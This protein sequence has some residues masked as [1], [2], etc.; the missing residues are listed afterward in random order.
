MLG[1][2]QIIREEVMK[3]GPIS[4]ARFMELA[5]YCPES[6]F[7]EKEPDNVGRGG[8]FYTSVSVGPLFGELLAFQFSRWLEEH[9][10][11]GGRLV[12]AGAHDG[13]LAADILGW[14]QRQRPELLA[15]IEYCIVEPSP[16]RREWQRKMLSDFGG[17]V[18]WVDNLEGMAMRSSERPSSFTICFSNE[19]L[20]AM[21]V[22]RFAW[23]AARR[24]W[25][26]WGVGVAGDSFA[27]VHL[28]LAIPSTELGLPAAPELLDVLPDGFTHEFSPAAEAWWAEAARAVPQGLLLTFDYGFGADAQLLPDRLGGTLRAYR[29]HKQS[30]DVLADPGEQDITAHVDFGRIERAGLAAGLRT[31]R[32]ER[33]G[34]YLTG[35][36]AQAW[37]TD[38]RFGSWDAGRTRQFQTL[39]HPQHLG[40]SFRVL[41]QSRGQLF[42]SV[43]GS[44]AL[45]QPSHPPEH[46]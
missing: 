16:R 25:F 23:D 19:L 10:A 43:P 14:L 17:H 11:A 40:G 1:L 38:S 18:Q 29:G 46:K 26:E 30:A 21:P 31:Q 37:E 41:I 24:A 44:P 3:Q 32:F 39:V 36:A 27:W 12:E 28:P 15:R 9:G 13:R 22:R 20:D 45:Q 5:L 42:A 33:Q 35:L 34:R 7:Y 8:H 4:F 6:G 2:P